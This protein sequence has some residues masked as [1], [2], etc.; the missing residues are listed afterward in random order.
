MAGV[1]HYVEIQAIMNHDG[2]LDITIKDLL[3]EKETFYVFKGVY[4]PNDPQPLSL[5]ETLLSIVNSTQENRSQESLQSL[6]KFHNWLWRKP[7]P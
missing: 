4:K 1:I 5:A 2:K 6:S 7:S 3:D